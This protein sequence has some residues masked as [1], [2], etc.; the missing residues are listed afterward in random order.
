MAGQS[1]WNL[2]ECKSPFSSQPRQ[3]PCEHPSRLLLQPVPGPPWEENPGRRGWDQPWKGFSSLDKW[4]GAAGEPPTRHGRGDAAGGVERWRGGFPAANSFRGTLG[5]KQG[6]H[7]EGRACSSRATPA[8][9]HRG[10]APQGVKPT[11]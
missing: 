5:Q 3:Q 11:L 6:W 9:S 2:L 7:S 8:Q 1:P 4:S 10:S